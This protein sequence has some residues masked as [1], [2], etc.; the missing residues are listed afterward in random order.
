MNSKG[1]LFTLAIGTMA[2]ALLAVAVF[3]AQAMLRE[4]ESEDYL[5]VMGDVKMAWANTVLVFDAATADAAT[6]ALPGCGL[7]QGGFGATYLDPAIAKI[8]SA[9]VTCDYSFLGFSATPGAGSCTVAATIRITCSKALKK[10]TGAAEETA[11]SVSFT[12]SVAFS[13]TAT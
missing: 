4:E 2:V 9:G 6:T 11:F 3:S 13:K 1:G 12:K 10:G 7:A 5:A 8:N